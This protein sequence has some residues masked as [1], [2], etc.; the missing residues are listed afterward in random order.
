MEPI[1]VNGSMYKVVA[2]RPGDSTE[3]NTAATAAVVAIPA[4]LPPS[5]PP[6]SSRSLH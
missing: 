4:A 6:S 1:E 2:E 5:S 3:V